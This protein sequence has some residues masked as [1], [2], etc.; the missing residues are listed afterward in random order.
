MELEA[1]G[2]VLPIVLLLAGLSDSR[3]PADLSL[4]LCLVKRLVLL[5]NLFPIRSGHEGEVVPLALEV[6][7]ATH[8]DAFVPDGKRRAFQPKMSPATQ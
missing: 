4:A 3:L 8:G 2:Q 1:S 6:T 7:W 5:G